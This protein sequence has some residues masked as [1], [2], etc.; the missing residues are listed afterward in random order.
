[1][2][3]WNHT[4]LWLS[5]LRHLYLQQRE[6]P[7]VVA[8]AQGAEEIDAL[9]KSCEKELSSFWTKCVLEGCPRDVLGCRL[10]ALLGP[11]TSEQPS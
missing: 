4:S 11:D 6:A 1:M 7:L 3:F 5:S 10:Q 9:G 8:K 2:V